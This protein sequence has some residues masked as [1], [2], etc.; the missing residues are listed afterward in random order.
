[1]IRDAAGTPIRMIGL[2]NDVT[3]RVELLAAERR[4][5]AAAEEAGA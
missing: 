4:S 2:T 3:E 1:M 5:R